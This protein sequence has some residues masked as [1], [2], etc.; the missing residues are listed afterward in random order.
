MRNFYEYFLVFILLFSASQIKITAQEKKIVGQVIDK[1]NCSIE[2]VNIGIIGKNIGTISNGAGKFE[3]LIP[4]QN[5]NDSLTF[6]MIGYKNKSFL[7]R[8]I[9]GFLNVQLCDTAY[10][11]QT[12]TVVPKQHIVLGSERDKTG[13]ATGGVSEAGFEIGRVFEPKRFPVKI[14]KLNIYF[15]G[16]TLDT[17]T[18]RINF[19]NLNNG[20]PYEKIAYQN[21]IF[22]GHYSEG[23]LTFN[24]E[25]KDL[26][27]D[28][29]FFASVEWL[30]TK[31]TGEKCGFWFGGV[32]IGAR[33]TY[34]RMVS[35][36]NLEKV[37]G[38][39]IVMN[40]ELQF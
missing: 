38:G 15:R 30:P 27:I 10:R 11:I 4:K 12:I 14:N 1:N 23:W 5:E 29:P 3:L 8:N 31:K 35:Q 13:A 17:C 18:F 37:S 39:N 19:Y 25:D 2:F 21:L 28:Q 26:W 16:S 40:I 33:K 6:S 7:I 34:R 36:A 32:L 22:R 24:L 20:K 9:T